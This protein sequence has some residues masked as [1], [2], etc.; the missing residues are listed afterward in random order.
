M[1]YWR[2]STFYLFF[3]ASLGALLPYWA[4]YL[5]ALGFSAADIG[6]LMALIMAT[7]IVAPNVWGWIADHTGRRIA[8]V[9][10]ASFCATVA[11]AGVFFGSSYW[12]LALVM[13][14]FS[15]F[16]NASLPQFE[17]TTLNYLGAHAHRYSRIRLWGSIGFICTVAGLGPLLDRHGV[18]LLPPVLL[19]LFAGI[20]LAS[21]AVPER[22]APPFD[23]HHEPILNV[24]KRPDVIALLVVCF[25]MQASHGPYY[26]F[27]SIYLQ[28]HGYSRSVIG[29]LWALGVIAEVGVFLVMP[30]LLPWFGLR[31][32]LLSGLVLASLRWV[33]VGWYV[34]AMPLLIAAQ[35]LHA[36]SFGL[37][38]ATAI[39]LIHRN[40]VGRHQGRGQA[41]YSSLSFGAGGA[42]GALYSGYLWESGGA[43]LTFMVAACISAAAFLVAWIR[44]RG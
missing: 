9:R 20:W 30:R 23:G 4:L 12:W 41:L 36:A 29:Q 13:M 3:F 28:E 39:Q 43:T 42:V 31:G 44:V 25:L 24:L 1:P 2:L 37:F 34:D 14:G 22:D 32:L 19:V 21:L 17:A 6:E 7:K 5:D 15:F 10:I 27:Y 16:W 40:F 11:F 26:T 33:L 38:H 35:L 8:I 18:T